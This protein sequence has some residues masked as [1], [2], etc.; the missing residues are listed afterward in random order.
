MRRRLLLIA[1]TF[2]ISFILMGALSIFSIER[3]NTYIN[4]S[5]LMDHS[6]FVLEKI[7]DAE[8]SLRD[9]DRSE[10]GYMITRD[11]MYIRF[12]NNSVDSLR[13][14]IIDL[15][16]VTHDDTTLQKTITSLSANV[17]IRINAMRNNIRYVDSSN[18]S[19]PS[20]YYY[21]SRQL[22]LDCSKILRTIHDKENNLKADRYKEELFYEKLTTRSIK[23]LL[24]VFCLVTLFLFIILVKELKERMHYQDA[25]QT[26]VID[27]RRSHSELQEIAYVASHDLQEPLR[28]I[29]VF[30]NMLLYMKSDR[31][32][33]KYQQNLERIN[34]SAMR[35][36][37]LIKDLM[38]LTSLTRI[39]EIKKVTDLNRMLQFILIE[40]EEKIVARDAQVEIKL[41]PLINGYE[42]QLKILFNELL[43]NALKFSRKGVKP[44]IIM[45]CDTTNGHE[46]ADS[47]PSLE[48]KKFYRITISDN[49]IGFEQQF[50]SRMFGIF[51][52]LHQQDAAYEGKGI[53]LALCQRIMANHDGYIIAHGEPNMGA[54][55]MV[56]FPVEG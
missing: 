33:E 8:K 52:R 2:S 24:L 26:K 44:M 45:S 4:Y 41:M 51:Q 23:W 29:Q 55:F 1:V 37:S 17:A 46:L 5:S 16:L 43:D 27:L 12:L 38:S 7:Y 19:T 13:N 15:R 50:I 21:D 34:N 3:L 25:L 47:N 22:M 18:L 40:A 39:D 28:K 54:R 14:S 11:T 49:G 42:Q 48:R 30:S 9:V 10:R 35:M 6:G 31:V 20:Q 56:F 36:Q 53:G 32:D